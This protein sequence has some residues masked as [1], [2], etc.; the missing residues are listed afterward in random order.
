[1]LIAVASGKGGTGKTTI[2]ANLAYSLGNAQI[3]DCDVEEPNAHLFLK[4]EINER[5]TIGLPVPVVDESKCTYC[6]KCGEVCE[7]SA[8]VVIQKRVM[9]FPELCHGCG[10]CEY[11]CPE[12]AIREEEREIGV[13]EAGTAGELSFVQGILNIAEPMAPP[14]IRRVK[15]KIEEGRTVIIDCPPGTSCPVVESVKGAEFCVLVTEPTPFGLNDLKIAVEMVRKLK[16][17]LG[18]VINSCTIGDREVEDFCR[19]E[20]IPVL[21]SLPWDRRIA[22]QYSAG[23]LVLQN[24]QEYREYYE[25]LFDNIKMELSRNETAHSHKR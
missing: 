4:P 6:G 9:F 25:T 21:M 19:R 17:P 15:E 16:V 7:F 2:A 3:I 10:A 18:V 14:L 12:K 23:R 8:I 11:F 1:M 22:E 13:I 5:E 24:L 20:G